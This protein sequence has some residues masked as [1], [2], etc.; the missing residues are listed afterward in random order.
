[1]NEE[2]YNQMFR[3]YQRQLDDAVLG[4]IYAGIR[5]DI[6]S[7]SWDT[8]YYDDGLMIADEHDGVFTITD[9]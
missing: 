3:E 6:K 1:M 2:Q 9:L 8:V 7:P 5:D 4:H